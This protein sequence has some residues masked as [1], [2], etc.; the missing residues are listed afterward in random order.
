V[1][2][3]AAPRPGRRAI[4]GGFLSLSL[5]GGLGFY[6]LSLYLAALRETG[7]FSLSAVSG[8]TAVFFLATGVGGVLAA[9]MVV[10]YDPR[11]VLLVGVALAAGSLV[12]LGHV[13]SPVQLYAVYVV[14]GCG[15][16]LASMVPVTTVLL[17]WFP[18]RGA[19]PLAI[20]TTGLSVGG[21]VFAPLTGTAIDRFGF[22]AV[23]LGLG[24]VWLVLGSAAA[25]MLKPRVAGPRSPATTGPDAAAEQPDDDGPVRPGVFV[26][27]SAACMLIFL[28]QVGSITHLIT[29]A[30]ERG[31]SS[32]TAVI[33]V[34]AG[35]AVVVRLGCVPLV[36]RVSV[37]PFTVGVAVFQVASAAVFSVADSSAELFLGAALLSVSL[38]NV[39]VIIPLLILEVFGRHGH[40]RVF[41]WVSLVGQVGL[42]GGPLLIA[43]LHDASGGYAVP[44]AAL[45]GL[46]VLAA[47]LLL[48]WRP[49]SGEGPPG[50]KGRWPGE[51]ES[52]RV[53][54]RRP[55]GTTG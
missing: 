48:P 15:F 9:G 40:T 16:A 45:A 19:G 27:L 8:A 32:A 38:G 47:A 41:A 14:F 3:S 20:A 26:A 1:S 25:A 49:L 50:R 37:V 43:L 42:A 12:A 22:P 4:I 39:V 52:A 21:A 29:L 18:D 23:S 51:R 5:C 10:R 2:G 54:A 17:S 6:N 44:F 36:T 55:R 24:L 13:G 11:L 33:P 34:M 31:I 28:V 46:S 7:G 30:D 35:L 53:A